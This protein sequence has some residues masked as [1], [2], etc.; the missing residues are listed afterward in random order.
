MTL[1]AALYVV[2]RTSVLLLALLAISKFSNFSDDLMSDPQCYCFV[3][4]G[5]NLF[6]EWQAGCGSLADT[7]LHPTAFAG[8]VIRDASDFASLPDKSLGVRLRM[9]E[10]VLLCSS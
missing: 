2:S 4:G 8:K 7:A 5:A 1:L 10:R 3:P 6:K 9:N